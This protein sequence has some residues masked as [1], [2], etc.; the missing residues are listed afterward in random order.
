M[1][2]EILIFKTHTQ[3]DFFNM[4]LISVLGLPYG[5]F[6]NLFPIKIWYEFQ[7]SLTW[8]LRTPLISSSI[9]SP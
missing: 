7:K 8:L 4:I 9:W 3:P 1:N 6:C 2:P 5:L